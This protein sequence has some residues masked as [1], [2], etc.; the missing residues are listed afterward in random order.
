MLSN[1]ADNTWILFFGVLHP[2]LDELG[3]CVGMDAGKEHLLQNT[4]SPPSAHPWSRASFTGRPHGA[5]LVPSPAQAKCSCRRGR[6]PLQELNWS[7]FCVLSPQ[8]H[9][10]A[11]HHAQHS[12]LR[13]RCPARGRADTEPHRYRCGGKGP[14]LGSPLG[15]LV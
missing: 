7:P 13:S 4:P 9:P 8:H 2:G 14:A 5:V 3:D 6:V 11:P 15:G 12:D 10:E 1:S